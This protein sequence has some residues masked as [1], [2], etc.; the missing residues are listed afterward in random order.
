MAH[1]CRDGT[2]KAKAQLG[3]D[4]VKDNKSFSK[5]TGNKR[6]TRETMRPWLR[7]AQ[8]LGRKQME[9]AETIHIFLGSVFNW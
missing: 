7:G 4:L 8:D 2:R 1:T 3:L 6:K 5:H 9:K